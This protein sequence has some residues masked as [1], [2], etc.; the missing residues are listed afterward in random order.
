MFH[1]QH[2]AWLGMLHA[3]QELGALQFPKLEH[4]FFD[5]IPYCLCCPYM[6]HKNMVD[7]ESGQGWGFG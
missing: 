2:F 5:G 7:E 3:Y 6:H 4:V 1:P